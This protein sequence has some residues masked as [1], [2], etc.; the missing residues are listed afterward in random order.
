MTD[1]FLRNIKDRNSN[2]TEC[3][4]NTLNGKKVHFWQANTGI[5]EK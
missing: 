4:K 3:Y 2:K 5:P 1:P